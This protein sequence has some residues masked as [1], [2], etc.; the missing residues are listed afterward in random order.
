MKKKVDKLNIRI[1]K[2]LL[3]FLI[4]LII[5]GVILGSL[6]T[7]IL[8][9][10]DKSL[11][12]DYL[13]TYVSNINN[14]KL[15]YISALKQGLTSNILF[16]LIIWLLGI[17]VIGLPIIIFMFFSKYFIMGFTISSIITNFKIKGCLLSFIYI[18]P[19]YIINILA[20]LLLMVYSISLSL[21]II[22]SLLKKKT[23]DFKVIMNKYYV[24]LII[25]LI[26]ILLTTLYEVFIVPY[27]FN[28]FV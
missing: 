5:V 1:N 10:S 21:K 16:V 8:S 6:F 18:F 19:H 17:S 22:K 24:V 13:N 7:I 25:N 27:L 14:H 9:K 3:I 12:T 20:F 2:K 15:D 4:T 23:I 26:V 28:M 11:I